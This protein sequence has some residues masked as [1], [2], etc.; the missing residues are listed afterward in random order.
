MDE[1]PLAAV[2]GVPSYFQSSFCLCP[3]DLPM[4]VTGIIIVAW[5]ALR[6]GGAAAVVLVHLLPRCYVACA[7]RLLQDGGIRQ[8]IVCFCG[9]QEALSRCKLVA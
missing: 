3:A 7:G 1:F 5:L 8:G 9:C 2:C 4:S 6:K